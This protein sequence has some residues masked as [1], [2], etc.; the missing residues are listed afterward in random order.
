MFASSVRSI[1]RAATLGVVAALLLGS[2][3][4]CGSDSSTDG[5][6]D[7]TSTTREGGSG[8][9]GSAD[10]SAYCDATS[11]VQLY[12]NDFPDVEELPASEASVVLKGSSTRPNRSCRISRSPS[13][14]MWRV[15][16]AP[17]CS[18]SAR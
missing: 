7:P 2:A 11:A 10:L 14:P 17:W 4:A 15:R 9:T 5:A 18:S 3:A 6:A 1:R 12:F 13:R 8:G 16:W